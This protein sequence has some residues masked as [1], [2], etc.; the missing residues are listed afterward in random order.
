MLIATSGCLAH[1]MTDAFAAHSDATVVPHDPAPTTA[2][3]RP[4]EFV[5]ASG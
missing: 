3:R 4:V 2:T 5:M 1:N